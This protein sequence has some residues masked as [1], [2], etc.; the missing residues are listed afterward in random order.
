MLANAVIDHEF[1]K[2]AKQIIA[3]RST[4]TC[5]CFIIS[6]NCNTVIIAWLPLTNTNTCL[7]RDH[8][9]Y[10]EGMYTLGGEGKFNCIL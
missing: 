3:N 4:I 10:L 6:L 8:F 1:G 7:L 5:I 9:Q 2:P